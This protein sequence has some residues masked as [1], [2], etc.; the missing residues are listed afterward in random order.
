MMNQTVIRRRWPSAGWQLLLVVLMAGGLTGCNYL[1]F[2]GYLIGGPPSIEP[3]FD[4]E[5]GLS[6][7]DKDVTVAVVCY[8]PKDVKWDNANIDHDLAKKVAYRMFEKKIKV[9]N[10][11]RIRDWID[12]NPDWD[13]PDEIGAAFGATYVVHIEVNK[14]SLYEKNSSELFRGRSDVLINVWQMD[15]ETGEQ[16]FTRDIESLY[17][18]AVPRSTYD[19]K[20]TTFRREYMELLSDD[21]GKMFYEYY[22]GEDFGNAT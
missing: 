10:P 13:S 12:R 8:A 1:L 15:G 6:M 22:A 17:P 20:F 7:T 3:D 9:I 14:F 19:T 18:R 4:A 11:D 16:I 5:T 2:A 21:I